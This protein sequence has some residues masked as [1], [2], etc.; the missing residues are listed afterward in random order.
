M[1]WTTAAGDAL[2]GWLMQGLNF[3]AAYPK[4]NADDLF[5]LGDAWKHA[6]AELEK[7]EPALK[8]VTNQVP[9]YYVGDGGVA[10]SKEFSTLFDANDV[11][12]IPKLI[13]SLQS[14]GHD[15]RST[16]T[17]IEY[18]KIQSE[19]FAVMTLWTVVS[20]MSSLWGSAAV[21]AVLATARAALAKFAAEV[22]ERISAIVAESGLKTLASP[23][24]REIIVPLGERIAPLGERLAPLG[25]KLTAAGDKWGALNQSILERGPL[26]RYTVAALKGGAMGAGL[27]AGTQLA[28]IMEGHRDDGFDLKQTFQTAIQWGV[29]GGLGGPGHD[30]M[31]AKLKDSTLPKWLGGTL[32]GGTG[33][34]TGALG[35]YGAGLGT[36]LYDNKGDWNKVNK[37]FSPQLLIGGLAMGTMGGADH[38]LTEH[39]A[40]TQAA[41]LDSAP[42]EVVNSGP[43]TVERPGVPQ[44]QNAVHQTDVHSDP[45]AETHLSNN[46]ATTAPAAQTHQPNADTRVGDAARPAADTAKPAETGRAPDTQTRP[47]T[48]VD[49]AA[50]PAALKDGGPARPTIDSPSR[51]AAGAPSEQRAN[52]VASTQDKPA[53]G[54][55]ARAPEVRTAPEVRP[56]NAEP[57]HLT[58][59]VPDLAVRAPETPTVTT[60]PEV[61]PTSAEPTT[62]QPAARLAEANPALTDTPQPDNAPARTAPIPDGGTPTRQNLDDA[63]P[64]AD[65]PKT[66]SVPDRAGPADA[67]RKSDQDPGTHPLGN[68]NHSHGTDPNADGPNR[69]S[70]HDNSTPDGP[71]PVFTTPLDPAAAHPLEIRHRIDRATGV[72]SDPALAKSKAEFEDFYRDQN[73]EGAKPTDVTPRDDG[74]NT[75]PTLYEARRFSYEPDEKLTTLTVKVHLDEVGS[76]PT[77]DLHEITD[78]LHNTTD[79]IFNN[80]DRLLSGD[81]LRVELEFVDDPAAA[82]LK[83]S[84]S[85][86]HEATDPHVWNRDT[87]SDALAEKL[88]EH[89]GLPKDDHPLTDIDLRHISNDI[90]L[91]NTD[92]RL[93]GLPGTRT[94]GPD[95]L[96]D[97]ELEQYQ[98]D[99]EDA[100]RDGDRFLVGADPRTNP[101]GELINDGGA[102]TDV[103]SFNCLDLSLSALSSFYGDPRVGLPRFED[104]LPDGS[105]NNQGEAG[106][107]QRAESWLGSQ[108]LSWHPNSGVTV[109][110]QFAWLHNHLSQQGELSAALVHNTWKALNAD[111]T[112]QFDAYGNPV[113]NGSHATVVVY[114]RGASGPVWWDPQAKLMSDTPPAWMVDESASLS[115]I[116]VDPNGGING[117]G[118]A[119]QGTGGTVP[120]AGPDHSAESRDRPEADRTRLGLLDDPDTGRVGPSSHDTGDGRL[121]D[122]ELHDRSGHEPRQRDAPSDLGRDVRRGDSDRQADPRPTDL[123]AS[124]EAEHPADQPEPNRGRVPRNPDLPDRPTGT[125]HG[126]PTDHG[127]GNPARPHEPDRTPGTGHPGDTRG[128]DRPAERNLAGTPDERVLERSD[129]ENA[130]EKAVWPADESAPVRTS[131]YEQENLP[132]TP[133]NEE[134]NKPDLANRTATD[135]EHPEL[136]SEGHRLE[137]PTTDDASPDY[138]KWSPRPDDD[139]S[140]MDARE[141]SEELLRRWGVETVGFDNPGFH[142]EVVRE[143]A[144]AVD[145]LLTRYPDVDLPRVVIEPMS[146][147]YY[148]EAVR[149]ISPDGQ[150]STRMLVLNELHALDPEGMARDSAEDVAGGHLV[151]GSDERPIHSTLVHEFG[152][153]IY[154]E[155]QQHAG[156]T[157]GRALLDYYTST[158]SE[159]D[160][161]A[162][163]KWVRQLS[164]YSFREDG[165]FNPAEALAEAFTDVE[166]NGEGATEPAKVLYWHLLD[167]AEAH[168][169]RPNG[170]TR[171]P[172]DMIARPSGPDISEHSITKSADSTH[173]PTTEEGSVRSGPEPDTGTSGPEHPDTVPHS[174]TRPRELRDGFEDLRTRATEIFHA[175]S[176]PARTDELADLRQ[177]YADKFDDLGLRNPETAT[178]TWQ[179]LHEHDPA[180]A[181]YLNDSARHLLPAPHDDVPPVPVATRANEQDHAVAAPDPRNEQVAALPPAHYAPMLRE[182]VTRIAHALSDPVRAPELPDLRTRY[183]NVLDQAGLRDPRTTH[184]AWELL[185]SHDPELANYLG[186]NHD[187]LLP[188]THETEVRP[189]TEH[190]YRSRHEDEHPHNPEV[191]VR[192]VDVSDQDI[193]HLIELHSAARQLT[194]VGWKTMGGAL[195]FHIGGE[196]GAFAGFSGQ[197]NVAANA[198]RGSQ[199][200]PIAP[201]VQENRLTPDG[202]PSSS[203]RSND[204]ENNMLEHLIDTV[205]RDH[206]L[207]SEGVSTASGKILLF[208]EQSP[209]D[210]CAAVIDKFH[211]MYPGIGL[212]VVYVTPYPPVVKDRPTLRPV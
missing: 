198:P 175:Y 18:A 89:L 201:P 55:A 28:Q 91:A 37:S 3:G 75:A 73:A 33:G 196:S 52:L 31:A 97:L 170:F 158:R 132:V 191:I 171:L 205:L 124:V 51:A 105:F 30:L 63:K 103:R 66:T 59:R 38:G 40:A 113:I 54:P 22:L 39:P 98:W 106:G 177:Q 123:P 79:R 111:G 45:P 157:A 82:H 204:A 165:R 127:Q 188:R 136:H 173:L 208:S 169:V 8:S 58:E 162:F 179:L 1:G 193:Q 202:L 133:H 68:E 46:G 115:F 210:S 209:C 12:S 99:V 155:G 42:K 129:S 19:I 61:R 174:T 186:Q 25:E 147:E 41:T 71:V 194:G 137:S 207:N 153:S 100:L 184:A 4:G 150:I 13:E 166:L 116:E 114:P 148:A 95:R 44:L 34:I 67:M 26:V 62:L 85:A 20:L 78:R 2:P 65:L 197:K 206:P 24:I 57:P 164:G 5:A 96:G 47:A 151:A 17:E 134:A 80:G 189:D 76:A 139:W 43:A 36:Q 131:T 84:V 135:V 140:R 107:I 125:D 195:E 146:D 70:E 81:H 93:T 172:D 128:E 56:V 15:A 145:D 167:N 130:T 108:E 160:M 142:P 7:L 163:E 72:E 49:R 102:H 152:H 21:P 53:P 10:V 6:A 168:S 88:R 185:K 101:Y 119:H 27:D 159:V 90:A 190:Y 144:R 104:L 120:T 64:R 117:A 112:Q 110:D 138:S 200:P 178:P 203:F 109:S 35:M 199:V 176:D 50:A 211:R 187:T 69:P 14:L 32:T 83:V 126:I 74:S 16:A 11:H 181:E 87:P 212:E 180:L 156:K 121:P 141:V 23:L 161:D 143:F 149:N 92:N 183:A 94:I 9:Q 118:V 48:P 122:S 77:A 182:A 192:Q 60:G 29:G 154:F 86:P